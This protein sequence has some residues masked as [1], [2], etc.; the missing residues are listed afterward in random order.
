M[1]VTLSVHE[2][3][4]LRCF[5][6]K[7]HVDTYNKTYDIKREPLY[8]YDKDEREAKKLEIARL[9]AES[10]RYLGLYNY[11]DNLIGHMHTT[12]PPYLTD[13]GVVDVDM[14]EVQQILA[15]LHDQLITYDLP[16]DTE[17]VSSAYHY[18][19]RVLTGDNCGNLS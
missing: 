2:V 11:W 15:F 6:W 13:F 1:V 14:N 3:N 5:L 12:T 17:E 8:S 16:L 9:Y 19:V 18:W 10:G 4:K 7:A